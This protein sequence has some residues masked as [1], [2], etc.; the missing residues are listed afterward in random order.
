MTAKE[1]DKFLT[2]ALDRSSGKELWRR[3]LQRL[4]T[5]DMY[6][7][8]DS[9]SATPATDGQNVYAFFQEVGVVSYDADGRERW[10]HDPGPFRNFYGVAA[11]PVIV[12]DTLVL[13]CDQ[14]RGSFILGLDTETGEERWRSARPGRIESYATPVTWS[15]ADGVPVVLVLGSRWIDAY[16]PVSGRT[17]WS[18]SGVGVSPVASPTLD[19]DLLFVTAPDHAETPQ[20]PFSK[21]LAQYDS[22]ANTFLSR[23]E[24]SETWMKNH[25]GFID[26]SGDGVIG[27]DDWEQMGQEFD[28][29]AFGIYG[30]RLGSREPEILWNVRQSIPYIPSPLAYRDVV[31]VVKDSILTSLDSTSGE[32]LKRGRLGKEGAKIYASPVAADGQI[33][34]AT[35]DGTV[36]VV[37]AGPEWEILASNDLGDEIFATPVIVDDRL[38]VRT[39]ERLFSFRL[40]E[41]GPGAQADASSSP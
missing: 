16:D 11:S 32:V 21:L 8:T 37:D 13:V 40:D 30:I 5:T 36:H 12:A 33:Y 27:E 15:G 19:G 38:L 6:H 20:E 23:E 31:Y 3:E 29:E 10:R 35:V 4:R 39:R 7:D 41:V 22:D 24:V 18:M 34:L 26:M 25:F 28:S 17:A 2:F 14:V 1:G 9:S